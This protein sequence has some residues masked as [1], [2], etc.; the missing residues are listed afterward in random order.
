MFNNHQFRNF[1]NL[2]ARLFFILGGKELI[3]KEGTTQGDP[4]A[5]AAYAIGITPLLKLL[6]DFILMNIS[7]S[8]EVAFADDFTVAG[9]ISEIRKFWYMLIVFVPKY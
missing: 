2:P 5:M 7:M 4:T 3:A 9:K 6:H 1:Y 8:K